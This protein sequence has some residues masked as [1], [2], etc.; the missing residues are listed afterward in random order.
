MH[1][2][3]ALI[4]E[5]FMDII[6]IKILNLQGQILSALEVGKTVVKSSIVHNVDEQD[7]KIRFVSG[8]SQSLWVFA[9]K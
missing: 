8:G 3:R 4:L 9:T 7:S 5:V 6:L 2:G 1:F